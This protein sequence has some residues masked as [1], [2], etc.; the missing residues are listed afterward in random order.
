MAGGPSS[1][2]STI[3]SMNTSAFPP[4]SDVTRCESQTFSKTFRPTGAHYA[5]APR[6]SFRFEQAA[7]DGAVV[8]ECLTHVF[9]RHGS[10][11]VE[12]EHDRARRAILL[13]NR[14]KVFGNGFRTRIW[15]EIGITAVPQDA[16]HEPFRS[17]QRFD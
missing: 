10:A 17:A 9:R 11:A 15:I 3:R 7:R 4:D 6:L 14:R 12:T 5:D 13:G 2:Y 16:S 1:S 8:A